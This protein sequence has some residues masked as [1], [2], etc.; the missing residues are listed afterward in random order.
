MGDLTWLTSALVS[1]LYSLPGTL[2]WL[3]ALI[4][5]V[6][7]LVRR[8]VLP[9]GLLIAASLMSGLGILLDVA[10]QWVI[11]NGN[12]AEEVDTLL[13]AFSVANAA[14]GWIAFA[15]LLAAVWLGRGPKT[16]TPG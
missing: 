2:V 14:V 7:L 10:F 6:V 13:T 1:Q 16:D 12:I 3:A 15:L 5:G 4:V 11:W 9:G 8:H